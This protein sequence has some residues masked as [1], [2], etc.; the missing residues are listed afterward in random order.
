MCLHLSLN[1]MHVNKI[2]WV[3]SHFSC[4]LKSVVLFI[5]P[6]ALTFCVIWEIPGTLAGKWRCCLCIC[7][8]QQER[9]RV[10]YCS[11]VHFNTCGI[12]SLHLSEYKH[13]CLWWLGFP[14]TKMN[15]MPDIFTFYS[16]SIV[17]TFR[18]RESNGDM[19]DLLFEFHDDGIVLLWKS[20]W[21]TWSRTPSE[22]DCC[23]LASPTMAV[24]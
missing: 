6:G 7:G 13:S 5:R 24:T 4:R 9:S 14:I 15:F 10:G 16:K 23:G 21:Q 20:K 3:G 12:K 11:H 17:A 1:K 22:R 8:S 18:V 2:Q 19:L